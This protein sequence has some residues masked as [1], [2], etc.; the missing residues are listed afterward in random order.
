[1]ERE[2]KGEEKVREKREEGGFL[3]GGK[4]MGVGEFFLG[5]HHLR[6]YNFLPKLRRKLEGK[7]GKE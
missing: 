4:K 1:M 6:E 5:A 7:V 2:N 3:L